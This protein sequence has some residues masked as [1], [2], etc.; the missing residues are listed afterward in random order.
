M[1]VTILHHGAH[2]KA[3][4]GEF[5][6]V[7]SH[8]LTVLAKNIFGI[9]VAFSSSRRRLEVLITFLQILHKREVVST[10]VTAAFE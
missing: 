9:F 10:R 7:F 5:L 6:S 2:F 4:K 1:P 8:K 3:R